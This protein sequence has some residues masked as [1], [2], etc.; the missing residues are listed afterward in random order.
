MD[1][2]TERTLLNMLDPYSGPDLDE[3]ADELGIP[4][5]AACADLRDSATVQ[6]IIA[7]CIHL[8]RRHFRAPSDV[9]EM[10]IFDVSDQLSAID[11]AEADTIY[12]PLKCTCE[13]IVWMN[14]GCQCGAFAA[15]QAA[16]KHDSKSCTIRLPD[17]VTAAEGYGLNID[18]DTDRD[19]F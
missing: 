10:A 11:S 12:D 14:H 2:H 15:E 4:P 6:R 7:R 17:G 3:I 1:A 8:A 5:R 13:K 9:L 19:I 16:K 18:F